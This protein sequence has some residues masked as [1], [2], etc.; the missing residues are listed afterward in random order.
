MPL[1]PP[2]THSS[3][4]VRG[5]KGC[6]YTRFKKTLPRNSY[7]VYE[8]AGLQRGAVYGEHGLLFRNMVY[9]F[10]SGTERYGQMRRV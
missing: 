2:V 9:C 3:L 1:V 10:G 4:S 7:N 5:R 8:S 6:V